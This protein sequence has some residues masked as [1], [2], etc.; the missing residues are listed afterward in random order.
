MEWI[1]EGLFLIFVGALLA[2]VTL[3]ELGAQV[4]LGV[5][6]VSAIGMLSLVFVSLRTGFKVKFLA[7]KLCPFV[8]SASAILVLAG[9]L[10]Q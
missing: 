10:L 6:L 2:V 1:I 9:T 7:F 3:I 4:S 8:F 5:Y